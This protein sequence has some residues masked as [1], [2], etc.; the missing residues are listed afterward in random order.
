MMLF[1]EHE[2][3]GYFVDVFLLAELGISGH[4]YF[5]GIL[6]SH[7]LE[8]LAKVREGNALDA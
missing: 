1:L 8:S 7:Y 6:H 3:E 4:E 2:D 5:L